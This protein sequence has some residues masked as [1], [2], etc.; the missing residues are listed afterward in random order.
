VLVEFALVFV[1]FAAICYGIVAFGLAVNLKQNLTHAVAEG[2]RAAVGA[3]GECDPTPGSACETAKIAAAKDRVVDQLGG[4]SAA[5]KDAAT[6]ASA[7]TASIATCTGSTAKCIT[8]QITY[9]YDAHPIVP[10]APGLA[11]VLP[12]TLTARSVVQVTN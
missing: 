12:N 9:P 5:V 4:Q 8:V 10:S 2:A 7:L 3:G 11:I 6:T 1:I